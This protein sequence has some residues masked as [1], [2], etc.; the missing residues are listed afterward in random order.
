MF[1]NIKQNNA[2]VFQGKI[3]RSYVSLMTLE[4]EKEKTKNEWLFLRINCRK[5]C[6][7]DFFRGWNASI[8]VR[9]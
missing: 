6:A 9:L 5:L 4:I 1:Q 2:N 7:C 8:K 3:K